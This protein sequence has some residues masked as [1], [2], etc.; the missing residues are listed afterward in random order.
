[1]RIVS[2][3]VSVVSRAGVSRQLLL[4]S[5]DAGDVWDA[6]QGK[7]EPLYQVQTVVNQIPIAS[8]E[9][10]SAAVS[11]MLQHPVSRIDHQAQRSITFQIR[12]AFNAQRQL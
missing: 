10:A 1:M 12:D 8:T 2:A 6:F 9:V 5:D 7:G 3:C 11:A 4:T